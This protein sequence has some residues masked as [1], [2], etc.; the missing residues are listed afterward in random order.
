MRQVRNKQCVLGRF[1]WQAQAV[2]GNCTDLTEI[3]FKFLIK[4]LGDF[5]TERRPGAFS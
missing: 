2:G 4:V 1:V 3:L 5:L